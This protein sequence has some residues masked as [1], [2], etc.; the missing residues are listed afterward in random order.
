MQSK[1]T[2]YIAL[3]LL[4]FVQLAVP[5]KMIL[6][7]EHSI[8]SGKMFKFKT[9]FVD[10]V[11]PFKGRYVTLNY[12]NN[13]FLTSDTSLRSLNEAYVL[14]ENDTM[15]FA[16]I[17]N[18]QADEPNDYDYYF[19]ANIYS[20][21][22]VNK[23]LSKHRGSRAI[24]DSISINVSF[25]FKRFYMDEGKAPMAED[26]YFEY[27][28]DQTMDIYAEVILYKNNTVLWDLKIDNKSIYEWVK[29]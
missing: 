20:Y 16:Q 1:K 18:I 7:K 21:N 25:P 14:I 23:R 15:G 5:V 2:L 3:V 17:K 8:K 11:D 12:D 4:V 13:L 10:P 28:R 26:L 6:E 19:K 27:S 29:K 22:G 24:Q 9:R